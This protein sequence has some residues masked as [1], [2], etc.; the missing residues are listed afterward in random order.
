MDYSEYPIP[1]QQ[2]ILYDQIGFGAPPGDPELHDLFYDY[3]YNDELS[4][5]QRLNLYDQLIDRIESLYGIDFS[6]VWDWEDFRVWYESP[7]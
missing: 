4:L 7:A 5:G 1:D 2:E 3:Y 6:D